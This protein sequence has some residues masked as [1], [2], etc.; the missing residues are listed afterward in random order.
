MPRPLKATQLPPDLL[1]EITEGIL[2]GQLT[3]KEAS[4]RCEERG[5]KICHAAIWKYI[6]AIKERKTKPPAIERLA[7][8]KI[9]SPEQ[10][11]EYLCTLLNTIS[12]KLEAYLKEAEHQPASEVLPKLLMASSQI[13]ELLVSIERIQSK[14]PKP[15]K[16]YEQILMDVVNT[17][18]EIDIPTDIL[19]KLRQKLKAKVMGFGSTPSS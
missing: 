15:V 8:Q 12:S 17:L 19:V 11:L 1:E 10:A 18:E 13:T 5:I 3:Y 4:R 16:S 6:Q 14:M 9:I 7:E 2:S